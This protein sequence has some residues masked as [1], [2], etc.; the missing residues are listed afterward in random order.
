MM[1]RPVFD[2]AFDPEL[3]QL[4]WEKLAPYLSK[5]LLSQPGLKPFLSLLGNSRILMDQILNSLDPALLMNQLF[6]SPSWTQSKS[7][8][9]FLNELASF[10]KNDSIETFK[11]SLRAYKYREMIR[12]AA[13]DLS[14]IVPFEEIGREWA[15]LAAACIETSLKKILGKNENK[16]CFTVL[17]LG[18]LG[19]YDLNISSDVDLLYIHA[20]KAENGNALSRIAVQLTEIL[21]ERTSDGIVFRVD[22]DLRPEG[23]SGILVNPVEA[24]VQYYE[25][26]GAPWERAALSKARV[27][28]GH[29]P[30]GAE[31]LN[32]L[33]PFIFPR[34]I[35]GDTIGALKEMKEKIN[36]EISRS[37]PK[38]YHLKSGRGGIREIEFFVTAF[39]LIYGGKDASLRETHT[40]T[41]LRKLATAGLVPRDEAIRLEEAYILF[42]RLENRLQVMEERQTHTLPPEPKELA[43][44]AR[45]T[46]YANTERLLEDLKHKTQFVADCFERLAS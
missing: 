35:S 16:F 30:G 7:R 25:I 31:L 28:A 12:I 9:E 11:H 3:A 4:Q 38:G 5:S 26:A 24:M 21:Q 18:K 8:N 14:G 22:L 34:S 13:K 33:E 42:R 19:G 23:R 20:D 41:A 10:S 32:Q 37:Q 44:L 27:V 39:Q 36:R 2:H 17:G 1:I 40:L 29:A 43:G 15:E 6:S 45:S 46:G